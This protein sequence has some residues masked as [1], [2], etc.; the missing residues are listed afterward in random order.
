[1]LA[2]LGRDRSLADELIRQ[3]RGEAQAEAR[4]SAVSRLAA[5][6]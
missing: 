4:D 3:R 6:R 5:K 2:D 1:M